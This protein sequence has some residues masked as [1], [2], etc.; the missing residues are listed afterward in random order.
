MAPLINIF[1]GLAKVAGSF[2]VGWGVLVALSG[3][4]DTNGSTVTR[5]SWLIAGGIMTIALASWIG[6]I[7]LQSLSGSLSSIP[8]PDF[9]KMSGESIV[10]TYSALATLSPIK[11]F[12]ATMFIRLIVMANLAGSTLSW[13]TGQL[14]TGGSSVGSVGDI[15]GKI[16]NATQILGTSF[17]VFFAVTEIIDE[18]QSKQFSGG[19]M[20]A[21]EVP[22]ALVLRIAII[23]GLVNSENFLKNLG[24][25]FANIL[26]WFVSII[27]EQNLAGVI[28]NANNS[29]IGSL[30]DSISKSG[31]LEVLL[32]TVMGIFGVLFLIIAIAKVLGMAAGV[33]LKFI[34]YSA[35]APV[36][37]AS[38][39]SKEF[40]QIGKGWF[41]GFLSVSLEMGFILLGIYIGSAVGMTIFNAT[42]ATTSKT[43][44]I[45]GAIAFAFSLQGAAEAGQQLGR[46]VL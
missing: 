8:Q 31:L 42:I 12:A 24:L 13:V 33:A 1:V 35:V 14:F 9:K 16:M 27:Q 37:V 10:S 20:S 19:E 6:S 46:S 38:F 28:A 11:R 18:V 2:I 15:A 39:V 41:K 17:F 5:G 36:A 43:A 32:V 4:K 22:L 44:M 21:V 23:F 45:L 40:E 25:L 26:T 29:A 34:G 3:F 30:I 7:Q